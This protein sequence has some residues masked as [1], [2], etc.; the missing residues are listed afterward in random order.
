MR[1]EVGKHMSLPRDLHDP[2][3][4]YGRAY[5]P[6]THHVAQLMASWEDFRPTPIQSEKRDFKRMNKM[7]ISRQITTARNTQLFMQE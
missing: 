4:K 6:D 1:H 5:K 2:S 3:H 7:A